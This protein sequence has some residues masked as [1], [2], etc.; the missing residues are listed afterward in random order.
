MEAKR[1]YYVDMRSGDILE[2]PS[3]EE[4]AGLHILATPEEREDLKRFFDDNY[5]DDVSTF[6]RSHIP[7]KQY[8]DD[9]QD[10][11]YDKSLQ[12]VYARIYQLGDTETKRHIEKIG[13]LDEHKPHVRD[14]IENLK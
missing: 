3:F 13:V 1:S 9:P 11:N 5:D 7:F 12:Q 14:D 2:E 6:F 8:H 10:A 4:S